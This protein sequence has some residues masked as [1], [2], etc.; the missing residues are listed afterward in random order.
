MAGAAYLVFLGVTS[1]IRAVRPGLP[2][3]T[4][5]QDTASGY[6]RQGLLSNLGNPKSL[7][8]FASLLP[9]FVERGQVA[10]MLAFGAVFGAITLAWLTGYVI[11]VSGLG[12]YVTRPSVQKGIEGL[13]GIVLL[14]LG[15]HIVLDAI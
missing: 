10:A 2:D 5:T 6:Y 15:V 7:L 13:A 8:F 3:A 11:A 14:A 12:T 4:S 9:Q 1:L